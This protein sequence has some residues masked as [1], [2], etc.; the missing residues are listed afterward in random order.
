[1]RTKA[2]FDAALSKM[3]STIIVHRED[4]GSPC[5]CLTP[6]G[7]RDPTWHLVNTGLP[8]CNEQGFLTTATDIAI[9]GSVQPAVTRLA[10]SSQRVNDLLGDVQLGDKIAI[11]PCDWNGH[12]VDLDDWSEAGED[13]LIYDQRRYAVVSYDKLPDVDGDPGHHW[14]VGLRLL[15]AARPV[16]DPTALLLPDPGLY[17]NP[18]LYPVAA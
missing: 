6:E 18:D 15:T 13:Y 17:P 3:G 14:E 5:P 1:M 2:R 8:V 4:G 9:K 11:L 7:F 12:S 16:N 10:R